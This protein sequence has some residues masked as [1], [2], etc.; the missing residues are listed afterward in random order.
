MELLVLLTESMKSNAFFL[1][2][3]EVCVSASEAGTSP[4]TPIRAF[5]KVIK[6]GLLQSIWA[7]FAAFPF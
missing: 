5:P 4:T 7:F 6:R 1:E 3:E 2:R